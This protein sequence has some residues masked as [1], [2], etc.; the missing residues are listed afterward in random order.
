MAM[1]G[2]DRAEPCG[3][4]RKPLTKAGYLAGSTTRNCLTLVIT[5]QL[6]HRGQDYLLREMHCDDLARILV[7]EQAAQAHPWTE[8]HFQSSLNSSH[9]CY[10]LSGGDQI[11]AYAIIS[12]AADEAELLNITVAPSTQRQGLG[13]LLLEQLSQ[14]FSDAI[15][16]LFLEVRVSNQAAIGLYETLG[17][18]ELGVRPNYYPPT[19]SSGRRE[20]AIIMALT[21]AEPTLGEPN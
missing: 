18:N 7:I 14:S 16:T 5:T 11:V 4:A 13:G 8:G 2:V 10:V 17:F 20:D 9:H 12:T 21:V 6:H 3:Y 1:S 19:T 15:H